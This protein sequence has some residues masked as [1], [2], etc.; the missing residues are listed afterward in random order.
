MSDQPISEIKL[1]NRR[2]MAW[3]SFIQTSIYIFGL[4]IAGLFVP[5]AD[6]AIASMM[7]I[8]GIMLAFLASP[9]FIYFG[10]AS[11]IDRI[12]GRGGD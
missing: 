11:L 4:T 10:A 3:L 7:P 2:K 8:L 9:V 1:T 6:V 5:G 12:V